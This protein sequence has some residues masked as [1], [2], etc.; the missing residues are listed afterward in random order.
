MTPP[1]TAS[2]NNIFKIKPPILTAT[3]SA[4]APAASMATWTTGEVRFVVICPMKA[5]IR[6]QRMVFFSRRPFTRCGQVAALGFARDYR[7]RF[8]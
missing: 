1:N 8:Q 4:I 7:R 3:K 5:I 2:P 6:I